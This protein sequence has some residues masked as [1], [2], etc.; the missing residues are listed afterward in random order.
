[1]A[2]LHW[3]LDSDQVDKAAPV[4]AI[5]LLDCQ[6]YDFGAAQIEVSLP[7]PS[8]SGVTIEGPTWLQA[9][10]HFEVQD[11]GDGVYAVDLAH[12]PYSATTSSCAG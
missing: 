4:H 11:G 2:Q 3:Q 5:L 10:D 7:S 12:R 1:M 8:Y 9:E 6:P